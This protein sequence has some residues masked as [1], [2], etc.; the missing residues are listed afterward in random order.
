MNVQG[1]TDQTK[2]FACDETKAVEVASG[3]ASAKDEPHRSMQSQ[4]SEA[5]NMERL[6]KARSA[7]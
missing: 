4:R 1:L 2:K 3:V 6:G 5:K 7:P